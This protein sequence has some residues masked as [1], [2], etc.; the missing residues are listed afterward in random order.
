MFQ[1]AQAAQGGVV[2][3]DRRNVQKFASL[4]EVISEAKKRGFHV[5]ETGGQIVVLCH[6]GSIIIHA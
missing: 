4:A 6:K 3:R 2:R 5:I 1:S